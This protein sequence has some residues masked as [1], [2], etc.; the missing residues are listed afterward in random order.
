MRGVMLQRARD[1]VV[2]VEREEGGVE[3]RGRGLQPRLQLLRA[4]GS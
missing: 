4:A 2:L 3:R 1:L